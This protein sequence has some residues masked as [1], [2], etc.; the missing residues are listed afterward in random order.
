MDVKRKRRMFN[1][2]RNVGFKEIE[3]GFPAAADVEFE[4]MR[5]LVR[6]DLVPGEVTVMVLTQ[7]RDELIRRT[8]ESLVG[9]PRCDRAPL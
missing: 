7:S 5:T 9:L 6:E 8:F 1:L 2:L 4:F 3:V